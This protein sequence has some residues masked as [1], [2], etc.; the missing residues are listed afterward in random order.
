MLNGLLVLG[1]ISVGTYIYHLRKKSVA[2]GLYYQAEAEKID[3][4]L[5]GRSISSL[6][7]YQHYMECGQPADIR[8]D[9]LAHDLITPSSQHKFSITRKGYEVGRRLGLFHDDAV[10]FAVKDETRKAG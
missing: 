4:T 10:V 8:D 3:A 5:P 6:G 1:A 2:K 7:A 9:L